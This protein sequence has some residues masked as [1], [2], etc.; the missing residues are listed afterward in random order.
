M[1]SGRVSPRAL[2]SPCAGSRIGQLDW[3]SGF[4]GGDLQAYL[5]PSDSCSVSTLA[6]EPA[7]R[8]V[9]GECAISQVRANR[10]AARTLRRGS[11]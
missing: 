4:V 2:A 8:P 10:D 7:V 6:G 5:V 9:P 3:L 1:K 11:S